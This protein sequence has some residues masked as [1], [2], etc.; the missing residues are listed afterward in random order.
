MEK[1]AMIDSKH[2][3]LSLRKQCALLNLVRSNLYSQTGTE[4]PENIEFMRLLDEEYTRYPFKGVLR[5]VEYLKDLG[6]EVNQK[7]EFN[8]GE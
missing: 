6:H 2:K 7:L 3:H 1:I 4:I 8:N 5:M